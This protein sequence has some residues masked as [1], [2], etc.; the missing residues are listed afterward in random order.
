MLFLSDNTTG[1]CL[2]KTVTATT[3]AMIVDRDVFERAFYKINILYFGKRTFFLSLSCS[4]FSNRQSNESIILCPQN[5]MFYRA[6]APPAK[7]NVELWGR[8]CSMS[9]HFTTLA[10]WLG[11]RVDSK[12]VSF[13]TIQDKEHL[14]LLLTQASVVLGRTV[15][16]STSTTEVTAVALS[17]CVVQE[18]KMV[19]NNE[20]R[21]KQWS[22]SILHDQMISIVFP[23]L[24][25]IFMNR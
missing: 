14:I 17:T 13:I 15:F 20:R 22:A 19:E 4:L 7:K 1:W 23:N 2:T 25:R 24:F 8:K 11:W 6:K 10:S 5:P 16:P 3:N 21:N 9:C 12:Q 18:V